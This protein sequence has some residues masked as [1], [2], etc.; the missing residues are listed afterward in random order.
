M[1]EVNK[2]EMKPV[3]KYIGVTHS[4]N[5]SKWTVYRQNK[6]EKNMVYSG[7]YTDEETAAHASD[8]LA[9]KLMANGKQ[10]LKLNFPDDDTEVNKPRKSK[11]K[12]PDDESQADG[13]LEKFDGKN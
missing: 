11:R 5:K 6:Y 12:R 13:S 2:K 8:T 1:G 4:K 10:K 3:S 7:T 9:R